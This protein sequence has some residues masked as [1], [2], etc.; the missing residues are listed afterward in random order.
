[1]SELRFKLTEK[2]T[3]CWD[4]FWNPLI[5]G[6]LYGG[7]MGGGKSWIGCFILWQFAEWV[8]KEFKLKSPMK[9]PIQIGFIGRNRGVDFTDTTLETWKR[10]IPEN[11]YKIRIRDKEIIVGG[12]VKYAFGGLDTS[13]VVSKFSSAEFA[14]VFVDQAEECDR[15]NIAVLL[16]RFRVKI[17]GRP[18]PYNT[19]FTANPKNCFLKK[20]YVEGNNPKKLFIP[21]LPSENAENLPESY[22]P[23]LYD[24]FEYRPELIKAMIEGDW[25]SLEGIDVCIKEEWLKQAA[26]NHIPIIDSR[27]KRVLGVDVSRY[28]DDET[29]IYYLE[30]TNIVDEEIYGQKDT[31][32]TSNKI[33]IIGRDKQVDLIGVDGC[34]LGAGVVDRLIEMGND[35]LDINSASHSSQPK[36]YGN[37]RSEMWWEVGLMFAKKEICLTWNDPELR[38]QLLSVRYYMKNGKIYIEE[39]EEIKKRLKRSPD[40]ADTY[41]YGVWTSR[42]AVIKY[43]QEEEDDLQ[44]FKE[45][46]DEYSGL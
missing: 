33:H 42:N 16:S 37:L 44:H 41:V 15:D 43:R 6:I 12:C 20:E 34:G 1:M 14:V 46:A 8:I 30:D 35:V 36:K 7:A 29:V 2:Q 27:R 23:S 9:Y 13:D 22:I 5:S 21:A 4:A 40:R 10:I 39:K 19:I 17:N 18:L 31:A 32:Y 28:G 25:T 3:A 45:L 26:I 38:R 11:R 24:T